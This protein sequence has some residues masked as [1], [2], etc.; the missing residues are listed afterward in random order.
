M[1]PV[2][3]PS[4]PRS[5]PLESARAL[6]RLARRSSWVLSLLGC[7]SHG[8]GPPPEPTEPL[9]GGETTVFDVS[10][11]AFSLSA[12]N[13]QGERRDRFFVGNAIFN[14]NWVTAPASTEGL[15]GLGPTFN[16]ESC[17]SC[18]FKD[19]RGAPPT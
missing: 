9:A 8:P 14:R 4:A 6:A 15:D 3:V 2:T 18:H 7:A 12:R 17:S 10:P 11:N 19:G 13:L 1:S 5:S 16:A